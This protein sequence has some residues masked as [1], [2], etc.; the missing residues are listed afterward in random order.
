[1]SARARRSLS[2][3][4]QRIWPRRQMQR[5]QDTARLCS[6]KMHLR[7][8]EVERCLEGRCESLVV[9]NWRT[10]C[11]GGRGSG[12]KCCVAWR[13][14]C[15]PLVAWRCC[16]SRPYRDICGD[17]G[18]ALVVRHDW[19]CSICCAV[20]CEDGALG[21]KPGARASDWQGHYATAWGPVRWWCCCLLA[22][23]QSTFG[24]SH[25]GR[26][27]RWCEANSCSP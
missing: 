24:V 25:R 19:L 3:K 26:S 21:L 2:P 15:C 18:A 9:L 7:R 17:S 27:Q 22:P 23:T 6:T 12:S 20:H 1:M 11:A 5:V 14:F 13:A 16:A 4:R 8:N 10:R